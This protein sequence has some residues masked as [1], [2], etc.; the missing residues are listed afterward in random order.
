M[1]AEVLDKAFDPFYTTKGN[2]GTGLGLATVYGIVKNCHGQI[3]ASSEPGAG[4]LF[5][6]L[7]P[8]SSEPLEGARP[9]AL[10]ASGVEVDPAASES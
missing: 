9:P 2:D 8:P 1:T 3:S 10:S 4:T 7:L 6:I 5:E